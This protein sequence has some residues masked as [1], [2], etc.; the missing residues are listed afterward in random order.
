MGKRF[1]AACLC[2]ALGWLSASADEPFRNH[3]YDGFKS[4]RPASGKILFVGNSITNMHE[5]WEA[6]DN[7][8][9]INY[10]VSGAVSDE[11][12][13]NLESMVACQPSK[14]FLMIG[15]NDL[16]TSGINTT[17][18]VMGNLRIILDRF[19]AESP[20]TQVYVQ[21]ILPSSAH[22]NLALQQT[23]NDSIKALCAQRGLTY[24]DLWDALYPICQGNTAY[25]YDGT[26]LTAQAYRIWCNA[27]AEHVGTACVYPA[28]ATNQNG[29]LSSVTGMRVTYF[30]MLPVTADDVLIVGDEMVNGVE[31]HELLQSPHVKNRGIGWGWPGTSISAVNSAMP[32]ILKGRSD[33]EAPKQIFLHVGSSELN[34]STALETIRRNY[35]ALVNTTRSYAATSDI[36]LMGVLP[37]NATTTNTNRVAPFNDMLKAMA[38]S[39]GTGYHYV[40]TYTP[41]V[42]ANLPNSN[43][44]T[45]N[46]VY[47]AGYAKLSEILAPLI[48]GATAVT[49]VEERVAYYTAR[50]TLGDLT[51]DFASIAFGTETGEY[52]VSQA[53]TLN[54][55]TAQAAQ[56][57]ADTTTTTESLTT[58]AAALT[59]AWADLLPTI[60]QPST[61]EGDDT[62]WYQLSTPQRNDDYLTG[63]TDDTVTGGENTNRANTWWRFALRTDGSYDI[64]NRSTGHYISP[65]AAYN[66]QVGTTDTQPSAGWTVS[67]S[68]TPGLYIISSGT[69]QLNMTHQS[70]L[71]NWSS[72]QSGTDR[73]DTGCQFAITAVT[74]D[75]TA[76]PVDIVSELFSMGQVTAA[77]DITDGWY[78][79]RLLPAEDATYVLNADAEYCQTSSNYYALKFNSCE[80]TRPVTAYVRLTPATGGTF[81]VTALNGHTLNENCTSS[82]S[83]TQAPTTIT[84]TDGTFTIDKW[85]AYSPSDGTE[86]PYV[87]KMSSSSNTFEISRVTDGELDDYD[88][89]VVSMANAPAATSVGLNCTVSCTNVLNAGISTVFDHGTY[90][91]PTGTVLKPSDFTASEAS[92]YEAHVDIRSDS[93]IVTYLAE[94]LTATMAQAN[95]VLAC[96]GVGYPKAGSD[97][98]TTLAAAIATAAEATDTVTARNTLMAAIDTYKATTADIELPTDGRAYRFVSVSYDGTSRQMYCASTTTG[99]VTSTTP[100]ER[101]AAV[102]YVCHELS[103]GTYLFVNG[104]GH[105][106]VFRGSN[107]GPKD[108][109]GF[110]S[111]YDSDADIRIQKMQ[112]NATYANV[113]QSELFG[114]VQV[115]GLRSNGNTSA[116]VIKADGTFD[117]ANETPFFN[118]SYSTAFRMEEVEYAN[119][120]TVTDATADGR[121]TTRYLPF[122]TTV[123]DGLTAYTVSLDDT[124]DQLSLKAVDGALIPA[125]TGVVL[126]ADEP[127]TY[128]LVPATTTGTATA[129]LLTGTTA[130]TIV[131][132]STYV[133]ENTPAA[134]FYPAA[135]ATLMPTGHA[136]LQLPADVTPAEAYLLW[137]TDGIS[138]IETDATTGTTEWYD[139]KGRRVARPSRGIF[140]S[141][142]GGK[143][144]FR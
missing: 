67:Y 6:F 38:D 80:S 1:L 143:A 111:A 63:G 97:A 99:L 37:I 44:M 61:A 94:G 130:D 89:Y 20:A 88:A 125:S 101:A 18:H 124:G 107:G 24:I 129:S 35:L 90:F 118:A 55:L 114:Y 3:R 45:G 77:S 17:A 92:G 113:A 82:V 9:I 95:A 76:D 40:D 47:A 109:L 71:Y 39:L 59:A 128:S 91:F 30:G 86:S 138:R 93:I 135:T 26:H 70:T 53:E 74:G 137:P 105:Y 43:Y 14:M 100:A 116:F 7:P 119:T 126:S 139:L 141:P 112:T 120:V 62:Q 121:Y 110:S 29:G 34:G 102:T 123:P 75:P 23:T 84:G 87:G 72:G 50:Q 10:G 16:G 11:V 54:T 73:T 5:W 64:I 142:T 85:A 103:S 46:Y 51:T 117:Q 69:V 8:D 83:R 41:M 134:G 122:A 19:A 15:T 49:D 79:I 106:L 66:T 133:L 33:N 96:S 115:I 42:S 81:R 132:A 144:V 131:A 78:R 36:Y 4:L 104:L 28:T 57:L 12:V 65:D 22:N 21:S 140:V 56:L 52:P 31:W 48:E 108:N 60:N 13:A 25:T 68:E 27:I 136:W 127:G 32:V 58:A 2:L 98:R